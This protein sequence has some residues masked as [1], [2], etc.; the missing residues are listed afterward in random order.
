MTYRT[1]VVTQPF[2]DFHIGDR[3]R[4]P[5]KVAEVTAERPHMVVPVQPGAED[6]D[7][8]PQTSVHAGDADAA[9]SPAKAKK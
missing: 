5:V 6:V 8:E 2:E 9:A 1:L 7:D 4:D 3:I